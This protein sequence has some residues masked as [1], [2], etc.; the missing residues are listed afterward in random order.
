MLK[1]FKIDKK[2]I[3]EFKNYEEF[4]LFIE[5][6]ENLK[7]LE[8]SPSFGRAYWSFC[9]YSPEQLIE[10]C[11]WI[12]P[13]YLSTFQLK[14]LEEGL[15][16]IEICTGD[17]PR[18]QEIVVTSDINIEDLKEQFCR[19]Y[20]TFRQWRLIEVHA[21]MP[22]ENNAAND[23]PKPES[24]FFGNRRQLAQNSNENQRLRKRA[25]LK[26]CIQRLRDSG[27][28]RR[29]PAEVSFTPSKGDA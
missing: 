17:Y 14:A 5:S 21:F 29:R 7:L 13:G 1:V 4:L 8:D 2:S 3:G 16:L 20:C 25:A 12:K 27:V 22:I 9:Y 19:D 23:N 28:L 6:Q 15:G 18:R 10:V 24:H 11:S 26:C